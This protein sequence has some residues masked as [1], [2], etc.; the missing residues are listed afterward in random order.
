[1]KLVAEITL[2]FESADI[3]QAVF[4]SLA[5]DNLA[6]PPTMKI[7]MARDG[8]RIRVTIEE[9]NISKLLVA[10]NDVLISAHLSEVIVKASSKK[11][12]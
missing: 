3:A 6:A 10:V 1:V 8:G 2:N 12:T 4:S 11:I 9:E 5:P 7:A